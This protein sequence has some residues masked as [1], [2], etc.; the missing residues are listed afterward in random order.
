MRA[1]SAATRITPP[2][3]TVLA[4]HAGVRREADGVHDHLYAQA[5]V[6]ESNTR[7]V[8]LISCDLLGIDGESTRRI[9]TAIEETV[10]V[11]PEHVMIVAT[12]THTGPQTIRLFRH[13]DEAYVEWMERQ[14]LTA[15]LRA[16][17]R[18]E[19]VTIRVGSV[20]E[21]ALCYNRRL[22]LDDGSVKLPTQQFD[23]DQVVAIEGPTDDDLTVV[24]F[25]GADSDPVAL[26]VNY[27]THPELT[28]G[29][30]VSGDYPAYLR[31]CLQDVYGEETPVL[32]FPGAFG[33]LSPT[34]YRSSARE[35]RNHYEDPKGLEKARQAGRLLAGS[36]VRARETDPSTVHDTTVG[37]LTDTVALDTCA[38]SQV[39]CDRARSTLSEDP[40]LRERVLARC[41]LE[42]ETYQR[43][44]QTV[45]IKVQALRL[46][47]LTLFGIPG[48]P[49]V[50][51]GKQVRESVPGPTVVT[52]CAN[53]WQGYFPTDEAFEN[54]G[55]E[56][57]PGWVSR[58]ERGAGH[59]ITECCVELAKA[60]HE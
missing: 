20:S 34:N 5:T 40:S 46:G 42:F 55:Y 8:V 36:S 6:V 22:L 1:G 48:E 41:L 19:E 27:A 9:R 21:P 25:D 11:D 50:E 35:T 49:F 59:E 30:A 29:S 57:T 16:N 60:L 54:G 13:P 43:D 17:G 14:V 10:D 3:G 44:N 51:H 58:F 32:F 37:G 2:L 56:T 23:P 38:P 26:L 4:G 15:V 52:A 31:Q 53:D 33:N 39:A 47:S 7:K 18:L 45:Q 12:H 28:T 24:S